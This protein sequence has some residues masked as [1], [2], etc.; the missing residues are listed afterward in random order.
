MF[1]RVVD[2]IQIGGFTIKEFEIEVAGMDYG[3][4]INGILGMDFLIP[5]G[6]ILNLRDIEVHFYPDNSAPSNKC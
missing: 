6:P 3:F 2:F 4:V 5:S 1:A